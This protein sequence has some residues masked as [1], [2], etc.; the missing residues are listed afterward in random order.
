M[1][2]RSSRHLEDYLR[3]IS[4]V[5]IALDP[6]PFTGG[7]TTIDCLWMGVP[8][9]TLAGPTLASRFGWSNM[10]RIDLP[11]LVAHD[12]AAYVDIAVK[13]AQDASRVSGLRAGL[14]ERLARSSLMD[15]GRHA[16]ELEA[17]YRFE[18][19]ALPLDVAG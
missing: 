3:A 6:V 4:A 16:R 1:L 15:F 8:V 10:A 11:E 19:D 13:L 12:E 14:R 7:F 17:A 2:F 9:V 5:D 18:F